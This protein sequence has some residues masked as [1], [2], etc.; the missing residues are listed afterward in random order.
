VAAA[1]ALFNAN[2]L[3]DGE[4]RFRMQK[5]V[6]PGTYKVTAARHSTDSPFNALIDIRETERMITIA[7]GQET[8]SVDFNLTPR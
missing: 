5:R 6:P 7:P 2:V 3:S 4:G 8:I 1:R